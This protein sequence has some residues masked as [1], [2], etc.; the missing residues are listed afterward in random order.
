MKIL[1]A[2]A[3]LCA[4]LTGCTLP[5]RGAYEEFMPPSGQGPVVILLSGSSG[6][7]TYVFLAKNLAALGY[8]VVLIDGHSFLAE[9]ARGDEN[10]RKMIERVQHSPHAAPGKVGAVGLSLGGGDVLVH[11]STQPDLVS[12]VVAYYPATGEIENK[13]DLVRRWSVPTLVFAGD[14]DNAV[15][16][17]GCCLIGTIEAMATSARARGAPFDLVVYPRVGHGFNLGFGNFDRYATE[18][19]W[20][21]MVAMLH[22][23]LGP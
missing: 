17:H 18:D 21:R 10:L 11:A 4:G 22:Q 13:D 5:D 14:S 1:L 9:D 3:L 6:P 8:Y 16:Q 19:A 23:H 2:L 12:V 15:R 20:Q 7:P